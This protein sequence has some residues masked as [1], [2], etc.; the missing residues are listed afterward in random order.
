MDYISLSI[1]SKFLDPMKDQ[2]P[3]LVQRN[4]LNAIHSANAQHLCD[5]FFNGADTVCLSRLDI[6]KTNRGNIERFLLAV[7]FWGY[8]R[9][10]RGRC[11]CAMN[12][13]NNLVN[14]TQDIRAHKDM[15]HRSGHDPCGSL[16]RLVP[17]TQRGAR[18]R[19]ADKVE[20]T[21]T[22][23]SLPSAGYWDI[24]GDSDLC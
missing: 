15:T 8:P 13:W 17:H 7:L 18:P 10:Q 3:I 19:P 12:N 16:H 1:L 23:F 9:N 21:G 4:R 22:P 24:D 5:T 2:A 11:A 14:L 20:M 6:F